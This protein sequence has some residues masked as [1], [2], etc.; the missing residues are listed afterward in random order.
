[1]IPANKQDP[2]WSKEEKIYVN[3]AVDFESMLKKDE[4]LNCIKT[5]KKEDQQVEV[6]NYKPK[7]ERE[8]DKKFNKAR[9]N[10]STKNI[11]GKSAPFSQ[12]PDPDFFYVIKESGFKYANRTFTTTTYKRPLPDAEKS[13]HENYQR[14]MQKAKNLILKNFYPQILDAAKLHVDFVN[15]ETGSL[16]EQ[17]ERNVNAKNPLTQEPEVANANQTGQ[18]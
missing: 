8:E 9:Y 14:Q 16:F 2:D 12:T 18:V 17:L 11:S 7:H 3:I 4:V 1:M 15:D 6:E 13:K 10:A 5:G